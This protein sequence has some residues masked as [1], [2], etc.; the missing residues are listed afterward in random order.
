[1]RWPFFGGGRKDKPIELNLPTDITPGFG[2]C[3]EETWS[4]CEQ[5]A[6]TGRISW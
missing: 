3:S 1:M 4:P 2:L 5:F 6:T